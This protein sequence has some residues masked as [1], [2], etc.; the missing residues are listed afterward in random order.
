MAIANRDEI[1]RNAIASMIEEDARRLRERQDAL[2]AM[3]S[4]YLATIPARARDRACE[5][6]RSRLGLEVYSPQLRVMVPVPARELT[7]GQRKNRANIMRQKLVPMFKG[8]YF[9][10]FD[11]KRDP[12]Q[13]HFYDLA[14]Y[15]LYD[16]DGRPKKL[17]PDLVPRLREREVNGAIDDDTPVA[18]LL[19]WRE[20]EL[21][22]ISDGPLRG[23][24]GRIGALDDE[25]RISILV[26]L[27]GRATPVTLTTE[28]IEKI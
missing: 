23:F 2:S 1:A 15:P 11:A 22:R 28:Q 6:L 3:R 19:S 24:N 27:F 9:V 12:W 26:E 20:G 25:G 14:V 8:Y 16:G 5:Q 10:F 13:A 21:A 7:P 4:W 18:E 17:P